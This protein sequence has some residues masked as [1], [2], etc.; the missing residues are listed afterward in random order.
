MSKYYPIHLDVRG[1]K[2]VIIGGGKVAYRKACKLKESGADVVVIS[3]EVCSEMA[4]EE[5]LILIKKEYEK[6]IID[7]ALLVI[8]AT[9]NEAVNKKVTLDAEKRGI[10]INVVDYPERCS[11]VVP[12]TIERGDLCISISTGGA[13]PAV[14]KRIREELEAVFGKEYEEYLDLLTKMRSL[15]MSTVE[16][17]AKRRKILQRLA[18]KDIFDMVKDQGVESVEVKMRGIISG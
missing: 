1:K 5:G 13:S 11:F 16:D 14:A 8:A 9:D 4:G 17:G 10:M 12:S 15:A 7:G 18:K 3:P 6:G 2:C